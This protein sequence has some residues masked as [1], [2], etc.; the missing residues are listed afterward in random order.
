MTDFVFSIGYTLNTSD[1]TDVGSFSVVDSISY[2]AD[3]IGSRSFYFHLDYDI[4]PV[5]EILRTFRMKYGIKT[6]Y[7]IKQF[8]LRYVFNKDQFTRT[9]T[10]DIKYKLTTVV[11]YT[12]N[13]LLGYKLEIT[14]T[15]RTR[16][17]KLRY[18]LSKLDQ[19]VF[20][21]P[22]KYRLE[23]HT[24]EDLN[25]SMPYKVSTG[26]NKLPTI[27]INS[28]TNSVSDVT[29]YID[30]ITAN[31][32]D[33]QHILTN[34]ILV[35]QLIY[36]VVNNGA[37]SMF[38]IGRFE[39]R[40]SNKFLTQVDNGISFSLEATSLRLDVLADT[41]VPFSVKIIRGDL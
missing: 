6:E 20:E 19:T 2:T 27:V 3:D 24:A 37:F 34:E 16:N 38:R 11:R 39:L 7:D 1:L 33:I 18:S 5:T 35:P 21:F 14:D 41:T 25:F 32:G 36:I 31:I 4:S 9:R 40:E 23:K 26:D 22:I 29:Y 17:F 8:N 13:F 30:G 12:K 10:F 15:V 28:T